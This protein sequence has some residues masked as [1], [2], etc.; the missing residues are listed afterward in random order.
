MHIN[1]IKIFVEVISKFRISYSEPVEME[2]ER[3]HRG[4]HLFLFFLK[5]KYLK[6][7]LKSKCSDQICLFSQRNRNSA[8]YIYSLLFKAKF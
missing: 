1:N 2:C 4:L 7:E 3:M 5:K 8:C 6:S